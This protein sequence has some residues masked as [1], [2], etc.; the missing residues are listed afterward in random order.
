MRL[1]A[2][3]LLAA[4]ALVPAASACLFHGYVPS[5]T[6]VD[7][8]LASRQI[9]LA[10]PL[11]E[12]PFKFTAV[13]A[14]KGDPS[15]AEIPHLVDS[16]SRLKMA[17]H[18]QDT[19]MF[20]RDAKDG[21][22][23]RLAYLD[24]DFRAVVEGV[25]ARLPDW[26]AG[27]D[28]DRSRMFAGLYDHPNRDIRNLAVQE[29]DRVDYAVLRDLDLHPDSRAIRSRLVNV[30]ELHLLPI[31][32][33]LIGLSGD[34]DAQEFLAN[35][36]SKL[37]DTN[38]ALMGA[39]A[40]AWLELSGAEAAK[41]LSEQYL[42]DPDTWP[43]AKELIVEAMAIH[44]RSGDLSTRRAILAELRGTL[45]RA[46]ELAP[47]AAQHFGAREDWSLRDALAGVLDAN[48]MDKPGDV[49][50]VRHYVALAAN[51]RNRE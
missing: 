49:I 5:E 2:L 32:V 24:A 25:A 1:V 45:A 15:D 46:P 19:V 42:L 29:L 31:R 38:L 47:A 11:A 13:A 8:M 39:Y 50:A 30:S 21:T 40:T 43:T 14:L 22:W 7:R 10:R 35:G 23:L 36:V 18:P 41:A 20:A 4:L 48:A 27:D 51:D 3:I 12:S 16:Q 9:V 34:P 6:I 33:L 44:S 17:A 37:R 26:A 28:A